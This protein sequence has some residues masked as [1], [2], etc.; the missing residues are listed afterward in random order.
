MRSLK[1]SGWIGVLGGFLLTCFAT[2]SN[3]SASGPALGVFFMFLGFNAFT[4]L[5]ISRIEEAVQKLQREKQ[6]PK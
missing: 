6:P 3:V 5:R 2:R 4:Q 1:L